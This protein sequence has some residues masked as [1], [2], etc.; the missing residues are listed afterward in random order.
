MNKTALLLAVLLVCGC[1]PSGY[2]ISSGNTNLTRHFI[3]SIEKGKTTKKEILSVLGQP[4]FKTN[5]DILGEMWTYSRYQEKHYAKNFFS[6]DTVSGWS[7][8]VC[9]IFDGDI[10]KEVTTSEVNPF[11]TTTLQA[12]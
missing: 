8:S 1:S 12:I 3:D 4:Q 11:Q 5:N 9:I 6:G 2:I 10:V 7:V